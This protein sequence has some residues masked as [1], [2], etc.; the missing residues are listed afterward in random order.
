[1]YLWVASCPSACFQLVKNTFWVHGLPR[2]SVALKK[3]RKHLVAESRIGTVAE[4]VFALLQ[5]M[6]AFESVPQR[7]CYR[8]AFASSSVCFPAQND[9]CHGAAPWP[10]ISAAL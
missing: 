10:G 4:E 2:D 3:G 7:G 6:E 9:A 5:R 8:N 1:M